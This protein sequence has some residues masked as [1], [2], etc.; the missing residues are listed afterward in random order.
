M[1]AIAPLGRCIR[2][3]ALHVASRL[4]SHSC[5]ARTDRCIAASASILW[6]TGD[7]LTTEGQ[8]RGRDNP[9]PLFCGNALEYGGNVLLLSIQ[10]VMRLGADMA[11]RVGDLRASS[12]EILAER[13]LLFAARLSLGT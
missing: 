3:C 8:E 6:E 9:R 12:R 11:V 4:K 13:R 5:L 1:E 10:P 2:L 7:S